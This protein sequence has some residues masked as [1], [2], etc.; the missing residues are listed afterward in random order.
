MVV[1]NTL[2]PD[3]NRRTILIISTIHAIAENGL[4][5]VTQAK[6]SARSGMSPSIV[7]FYF[8][9]K[10]KLMLDTLRYVKDEYLSVVKEC[11]QDANTPEQTLRGLVVGSFD[12]RIF[13]KEKIA[14]WYAF[15]A[16]S[17][18]RQEYRQICQD[19]VDFEF[20]LAE[21]CFT[22]MLADE[23]HTAAHCRNLTKGLVGL[24]D[25]LW[26]ETL[27]SDKPLSSLDG[28]EA[29]EQYIECV[30]PKRRVPIEA[31]EESEY[32]EL[33]PLWTYQDEEFFELEINRLFRTHWMMVGHVC[34]MP[35]VGDYLTFEGFG[36][37]AVVVRNQDGKINA[38]HNI[39]RHRGSRIV[40]QESGHCRQ[41]LT[42][43][44]HGWRYDFDGNLK[45]IPDRDGFPDANMRH[46][47]LKPLET[48]VWNGF[49]FIRFV[50]GGR[51]LK[52]TLK[53]IDTKIEQYCLEDLQPYYGQSGDTCVEI[54]PRNVNWKI[55]HD[56]DNEGYHVPTGHPTLQ[57]LYG[58]SYIDTVVGDISV[59]YGRFNQKKASM[60]SVRNYLNLLPDFEHLSEEG[61]NRWMYFSIFPNLTFGLYPDMAEF[62]MTMPVDSTH[63]KCISKTYA[64]PD[65]RRCMTALRYLNR[66]MNKVTDD[67]DYFYMQTMQDG[68]NSSAYPEWT[69]SQT[70]ETAVRHYHNAIQNALPVAKLRHKPPSGNV[71]AMNDLI[72][73]SIGENHH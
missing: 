69:L 3:N 10:K 36:E 49:I 51:T 32:T 17:Q 30:L 35:S 21:K 37:K 62:Y 6:I 46:Y 68:L 8:K 20:K 27:I 63:T 38:F 58:E 23:F 72:L 66:R 18:A 44:F 73:S 42:C 60:W 14:V 52:D 24:I 61:Q 70:A 45:F 67:E 7:N 5:G 9:T 12:K 19:A 26:Q 13:V 65:S 54:E 40:L 16:E 11:I 64:L 34:E 28:I 41:S 31:L 33:L 59:S 15:W 39:C 48:E 4:T 53:P 1:E 29:C 22:E 55:F 57:Q 43:P 47:S 50:N 2:S 71:A 56:I 25:T